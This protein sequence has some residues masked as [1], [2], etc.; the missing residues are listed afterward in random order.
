MLHENRVWCVEHVESAEQL[1]RMLTETTRCCCNAFWI[2][3][4]IWLNDSTSSDSAQEYAVLK[5]QA[6][7]SL[8]QIESITFGWMNFDE[9]LA[10]IKQTL[11]GDFDRL[12][13]SKPI[14]PTLQNQKEHGRC[15]HCA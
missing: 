10:S 9:G 2:G 4:Y 6:D 7:H 15:Q 12:E 1:S 5:S 3:D 13:W 8:V 11:A 14:H